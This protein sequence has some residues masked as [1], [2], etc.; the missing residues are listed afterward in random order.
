VDFGGLSDRG[1]QEANF[2]VVKRSTM[3]AA[4]VELA[5]ISNPREESLLNS[6]AFQ[7][8]LAEGICKGLSDFFGQASK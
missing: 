7:L 8:K 3:P 5:F 2:Y 1:T 4:L 6:S